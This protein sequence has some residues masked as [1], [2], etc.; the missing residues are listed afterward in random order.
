[1]S[2]QH[3]DKKKRLRSFYSTY[4]RGQFQVSDLQIEPI[5]LIPETIQMGDEFDFW[6]HN[7]KDLFLAT[8]ERSLES[9]IYYQRVQQR[10]YLYLRVKL[11]F[12]RLTRSE[13]IKIFQLIS[14]LGLPGHKLIKYNRLISSLV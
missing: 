4:G 2:Y 6:F 11:D 10:S 14:D 13:I 8:L 9:R 3:R 5:H 7:G 1:M 12:P